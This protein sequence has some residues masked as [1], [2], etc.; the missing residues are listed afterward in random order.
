[1]SG[2]SSDWLALRAPYDDAARDKALLDRLRDWRVRYGG[3]GILDLG[4]G[5]G[6][7]LRALAPLLRGTQRW[8]MADHD[9]ALLKAIPDHTA[10]WASAAGHEMTGDAVTGTGFTASLVPHRADL[11]AGLDDLPLD[12]VRLVTASALLDLV[13]ADWLASLVDL[14]RRHG[15]ACY[16]ALT[17]DGRLDWT[18]VDRLDAEMHALFDRHQRGTKSFGPALG[19]DAAQAATAAFRAAE[20]TVQTGRSDWQMEAGD[21]DMQEALLAGYVQ[22][23]LEIAPDRA[24]EIEHWR[25]RRRFAIGA[26]TSRHRVGH[27]DLLALPG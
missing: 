23:A 3:I 13:S 24:G 22:A 2:F 20:F 1:M 4:C 8:V 15:L 16:A 9:P 19:P 11:A 27:T 18:P 5:T 21:R 6:A 7:S 26:G 10:R 25:Q 17:Y 14:C 12:G